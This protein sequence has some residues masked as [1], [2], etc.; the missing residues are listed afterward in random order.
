[1]SSRSGPAEAPG[2]AARR[3]KDH[4]SGAVMRE[5]VGAEVRVVEYNERWLVGRHGYLTP[6]QVRDL[7]IGWPAQIA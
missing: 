7:R 6:R 4:V 3:V 1:M 2:I 5:A